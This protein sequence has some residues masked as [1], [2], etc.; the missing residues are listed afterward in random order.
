MQEVSFFITYMEWSFLEIQPHTAGP[1]SPP[2]VLLEQ[3]RSINYSQPSL[4]K[5]KSGAA[6]LFSVLQARIFSSSS[7][8]I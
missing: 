1:S 8:S 7:F 5:R 4:L 3:K 2:Y 6:G